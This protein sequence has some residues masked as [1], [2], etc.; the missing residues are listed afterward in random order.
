MAKNFTFK[1]ITIHAENM[2]HAFTMKE[3]EAEYNTA[4]CIRQTLMPGKCGMA[5]CDYC[6]LTKEKNKVIEKIR[7][8]PETITYNLFGCNVTINN[9]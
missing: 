9:R 2:K 3:A 4:C 5:N 6:Y 8:Q 1:D 7:K